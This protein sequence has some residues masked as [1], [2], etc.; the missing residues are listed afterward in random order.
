MLIRYRHRAYA[1]PYNEHNQEIEPGWLLV[2]ESRGLLFRAV[3]SNGRNKAASGELTP[4]LIKPPK[5]LPG[6]KAVLWQGK[7][8]WRV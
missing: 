4:K 3:E 2:D 7:V 8:Y 5:N 6:A 1:T